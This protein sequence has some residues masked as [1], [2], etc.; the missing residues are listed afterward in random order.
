[1]YSFGVDVWFVVMEFNS[2]FFEH[3]I[4][5]TEGHRGPQSIALILDRTQITLIV[6]SV[7][8]MLISLMLFTYVDPS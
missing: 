3:G 8:I 5:I 1:M 2:I 7:F 4:E 6:L